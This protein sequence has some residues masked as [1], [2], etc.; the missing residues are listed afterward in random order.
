MTFF[1]FCDSNFAETVWA[2]LTNCC[3]CLV[4]TNFGPCSVIKK[5]L[6]IT[7]FLCSAAYHWET[8]E[9]IPDTLMAD[10]ESINRHRSPTPPPLLPACPSLTPA[11]MGS[12][13]RLGGS[14]QS[15]MTSYPL[16]RYE[17]HRDFYSSMSR[18]KSLVCK[19][20]QNEE[21]L[22]QRSYNQGIASSSCNHSSHREERLHVWKD[23]H[24]FSSHREIGRYGDRRS[25]GA[26]YS[27]SNQHSMSVSKVD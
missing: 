27:H 12:S 9:G 23:S 24:S 8:T 19:E 10:L 13:I 6:V 21:S 17:G 3:D 22:P 7:V 26:Q 4:F 25:F 5:S 15:L 1:T 18:E 11:Q 14:T 20:C 2:G 16:H